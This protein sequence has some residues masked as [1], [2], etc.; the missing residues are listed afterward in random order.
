M[1][2]SGEREAEVKS[3]Q[4]QLSPLQLELTRLRAELQEKIAQEEQLRQQS[5]EK[6]EKTKK[7]ILVAKQR[8]SLLNSECRT[9]FIK[10]HENISSISGFILLQSNKCQL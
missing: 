10:C 4:E 8:I 6:E 1:Q 9:R 2:T 7:A 5:V 3:L